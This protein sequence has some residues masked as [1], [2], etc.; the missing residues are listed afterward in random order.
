[1]MVNGQYLNSS[2]NLKES[3]IFVLKSSQFFVYQ[4]VKHVQANRKEFLFVLKTRL[5]CFHV[6]DTVPND[7]K[8]N[9]LR[10]FKKRRYPIILKES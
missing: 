7:L 10:F 3:C 8:T 4:Y 9:L 6:D 1:M 2:K 5:I